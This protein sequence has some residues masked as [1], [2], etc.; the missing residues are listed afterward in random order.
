MDFKTMRTIM[1]SIH[2]Q[3]ASFRTGRMEGRGLHAIGIRDPANASL[4]S[5]HRTVCPAHH[6][7]R[8]G[9]AE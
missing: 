4:E 8:Y 3:A 7:I 6:R 1:V 9:E 2:C 5:W